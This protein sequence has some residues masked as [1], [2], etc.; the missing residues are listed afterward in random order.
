MARGARTSSST[1][2]KHPRS[3]LGGTPHAR[4]GGRNRGPP[5]DGPGGLGQGDPGVRASGPEVRL[6]RCVLSCHWAGVPR[7]PGPSICPYSPECVE[8]KFSEV[9]LPLY[10]VLR[11]SRL[12]S[13]DGII[14]GALSDS[15]E[16]AGRKRRRVNATSAP[17]RHGSV[18][19][20]GWPRRDDLPGHA[21]RIGVRSHLPAPLARPFGRRSAPRLLRPSWPRSLGLTAFRDDHLR[22]ALRRCRRLAR[23]SGLREG[24]R[25]GLLFRRVYRPGVR[26]ALPRA[27]KPPDL[28][29]HFAWR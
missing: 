18:L 23:A 28:A 21:R 7:C 12:T 13:S 8:G 17:Q 14:D 5:R 26:L 3:P 15:L 2:K 6:R 27:P 9:E 20:G 22:A 29:R 16:K 11:S 1:W 10:G 4:V 19:R 24:R 25:F